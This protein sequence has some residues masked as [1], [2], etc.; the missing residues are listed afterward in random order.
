M[1][2]LVAVLDRGPDGEGQYDSVSLFRFADKC[3]A[4]SFV[5]DATS[6]ALSHASSFGGWPGGV[7]MV[8]TESPSGWDTAA[9]ARQ[10]WSGLDDD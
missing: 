6:A 8:D 2:W 3:E 1:T 7:F 4:E 9:E 10:S 5:A